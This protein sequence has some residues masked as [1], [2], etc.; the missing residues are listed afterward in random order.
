MFES[1]LYIIY[2]VVL[3]EDRETETEREEKIK[4]QK[5]KIHIIY[6]NVI[7]NASYLRIDRI[8]SPLF[9]RPRSFFDVWRAR[10]RPRAYV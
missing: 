2:D 10:S 9:R 1:V 8:L 7:F 6:D 4:K 3:E 5:N